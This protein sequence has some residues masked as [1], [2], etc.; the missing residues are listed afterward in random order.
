MKRKLVAMMTLINYQLPGITYYTG[1]FVLFSPPGK[2]MFNTYGA[3]SYQ[4]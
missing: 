4:V 1:K 3:P 2:K